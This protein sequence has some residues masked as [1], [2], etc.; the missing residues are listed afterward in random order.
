MYTKP[1]LMLAESPPF[2]TRYKELQPLAVSGNAEAQF[3]LAVIVNPCANTPDTAETLKSVIAAALKSRRYLGGTR[4]EDP[5]LFDKQMRQEYADCDG[6]NPAQRGRSREWARSAADAGFLDAQEALMYMA[7]PG[8]VFYSWNKDSKDNN[9]RDTAHYKAVMDGL[10]AA[11]S[12]GSVEAMLTLG[13]RYAQGSADN[14]PWERAYY[15]PMKSY[16]NFVAYDQVQQAIGGKRRP[17]IKGTMVGD[18]Q[19]KLSTAQRSEAE[20]MAKTMLANPRCCVV[21]Q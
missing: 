7:R 15:D 17:A 1:D 6:V 9:A 3:R 18:M 10:I 13:S 16:A 14:P 11:R 5:K 4:V 21:T 2:G 19:A 8:N 20:A 12:A